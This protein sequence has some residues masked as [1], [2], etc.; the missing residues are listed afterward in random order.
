MALVL[1]LLALRPIV[2]HDPALGQ[3]AHALLLLRLWRERTIRRS[4]R[5]R[6]H[7]MQNRM[8]RVP[9]VFG[10]IRRTGPQR[11]HL[12][13]PASDPPWPAPGPEARPRVLMLMIAAFGLGED[14]DAMMLP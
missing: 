2:H 6:V 14:V 11:L 9:L 5:S 12:V 8:V 10:L 13:I 7:V 1:A 4:V 3:L